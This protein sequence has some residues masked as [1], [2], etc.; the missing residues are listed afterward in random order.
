MH[1][2]LYNDLLGAH[3]AAHSFGGLE[4][5]GSLSNAQYSDRHFCNCSIS[6]VEHRR[7]KMSRDYVRH[8]ETLQR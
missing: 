5:F 7:S 3:N 2:T 1:L 6:A 4:E 8:L